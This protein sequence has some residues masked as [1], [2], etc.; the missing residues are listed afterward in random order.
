ME[1]HFSPL[2]NFREEIDKINQKINEEKQK[3]NV[4][5]HKIMRLNEQ[6]LIQSMFSNSLLKKYQSPW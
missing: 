1:S 3:E 4:D 2:T 6:K 5:T